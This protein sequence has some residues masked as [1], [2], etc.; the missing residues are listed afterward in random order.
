M[1]PSSPIPERPSGILRHPSSK[2]KSTVST[3]N[4]T[5]KLFMTTNPMHTADKSFSNPAFDIFL[6]PPATSRKSDSEPR[7]SAEVKGGPK[8]PSENPPV[9]PPLPP[10]PQL[11]VLTLKAPPKYHLT[12]TQA[13]LRAPYTTY[14]K[15]SSAISKAIGHR[16]PIS[17]WIARPVGA[18][19][20]LISIPF[21]PLLGALSAF[22]G[23]TS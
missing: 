7:E 5:N 1:Q 3:S 18:I 8:V 6:V 17:P 21:S 10:P 12:Y 14:K 22:R 2:H 15:I 11:P 20:G 16:N 9:A 23:K 19:V 13:S 4:Q